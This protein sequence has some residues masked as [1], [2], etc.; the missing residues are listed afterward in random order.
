MEKGNA[1]V[2]QAEI[3]YDFDKDDFNSAMEKVRVVAAGYDRNHAAAPSL[4]GNYRLEN[5]Y[6][7]LEN[8]SRYLH[9]MNSLL[10]QIVWIL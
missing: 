1:L 9:R 7:K 4:A 5:L 8:I 3:D 6:R 10:L 2:P